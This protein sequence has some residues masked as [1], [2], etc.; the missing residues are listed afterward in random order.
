MDH[1]D[2]D[3]V[4]LWANKIEANKIEGKK[5]EGT[6]TGKTTE[7]KINDKVESGNFSHKQMDVRYGKHIQQSRLTHKMTQKDL[8]LKL[9]ISVKLIMEIE[10]GKAKHNGRL[11]SR[12]NNKLLNIHPGGDKQKGQAK[13]NGTR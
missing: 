11:M 9:N 1:Q 13:K 10:N 7:Q 12:I 2:W 3:P 6:P 8:A 5:Q 4:Y